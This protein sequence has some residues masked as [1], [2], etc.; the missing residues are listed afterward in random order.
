MPSGHP[1]A[2]CGD[3]NVVPTDFGI[4]ATKFWKKN[5]L[6]QPESRAAFS[7]LLDQGWTDALR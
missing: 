4:Y 2:L 1:V 3:Y 6:L 7:R 5:A